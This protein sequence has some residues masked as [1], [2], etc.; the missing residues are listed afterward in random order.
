MVLLPEQMHPPLVLRWCVLF[1]EPAAKLE[2]LRNGA[3]A[4][5]L[6]RR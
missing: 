6:S 5:Q 1:C 2:R 3:R 4:Y